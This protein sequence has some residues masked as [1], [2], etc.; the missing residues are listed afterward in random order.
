MAFPKSP[1]NQESSYFS[2]HL[3]EHSSDAASLSNVV[4]APSIHDAISVRL[5]S[6]DQRYTK[7]RRALVGA[8]ATAGRPLTIPELLLLVP[9]LVQSSAYRIVT[10]LIEL[11]VI[12]RV[13]GADDHG[14]FELA[15]AFFGHHH[16]LVCSS[17]G[18][19]EDFRASPTLERA[20]DSAAETA[21]LEQGY[22]VTDHRLE[23]LGRCSEC[24]NS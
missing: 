10:A 19:V 14:R 8:L 11:G 21:A 5:L 2:T 16:H 13:A 12:D 22:E 9:G 17:C 24:M 6:V 1:I 20:L 15:Q 18:K 23:L 3:G 4:L 7:Q